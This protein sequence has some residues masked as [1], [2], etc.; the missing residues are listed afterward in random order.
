MKAKDLLNHF[1]DK[2]T[3]VDKN[4]TEDQII[5]GDPEKEIKKLMVV[6]QASMSAVIK[7]VEGGFDAIMANEPTF[8]FHI[9]ELKNVAQLPDDSD[10]KKTAL[11]KKKLIDDAG[12]VVIRNHDVWCKFPVYGGPNSWA[13]QL[14]FPVGSAERTVN[15]GYQSVYPIE[16]VTALDFANR[17]KDKMG[18]DPRQIQIFGNRN[19]KISRVGLGTGCACGVEFFNELNCDLIVVCD[20]SGSYWRDISLA[21]D[22]DLPVI[23]VFHSASE[24]Y[25]ILLMKEYMDEHFPDIQTEYLPFDTGVSFI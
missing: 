9:D 10:V 12:L 5:V 13:R 23:R 2:A 6:W 22:M 4:N 7:A 25:G 19:K 3:W 11:K 24:D 14:G 8:Y 20:D 1:L 16:P 15:N 21:V 17:M 18:A